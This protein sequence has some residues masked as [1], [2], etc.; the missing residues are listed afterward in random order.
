MLSTSLKGVVAQVLCKKTGGGRMAAIEILVVNSAISAIIRE[1]KTHQI[2]SN[3]Q[4]GGKLG[5][6]LLNDS[7]LELVQKGLVDPMEAYLKSVDKQGLASIMKVNGIQLE[8]VVVEDL[9]NPGGGGEAPQPNAPLPAG[10]APPVPGAAPGPA[11]DYE[12]DPF[13]AYKQ[14]QQ[15]R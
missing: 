3:M 7:L 13:E 14:Q 8:G 9:T 6:K 15:G 4:M 5:M 12:V 11:G 2:P 10:G 1:G